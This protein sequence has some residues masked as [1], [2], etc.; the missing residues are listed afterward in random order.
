[1]WVR[2]TLPS[3]SPV[4]KINR[5]VLIFLG[6]A[7][8]L[9]I[10][11]FIVPVLIILAISLTNLSTSTGFEGWSWVG[12]DNYIRIFRH[13]KTPEHFGMTLKYVFWTLGL[14]NVGMGLLI[15]LLTT[16]IHSRLGTSFR[17]LWL[18]PKILPSVVYVLM[19]KYL[20]AAAPHGIINIFLEPFGIEARNWV[21]SEPF[22]FI[23]LI[24]GYIG[25]SFGMIIFTSAIESIPKDY[26]RAAMVDGAGYLQR[27]RHI[28][29]PAIKWPLLFVTTYQ[30]LSLLTSFEQ[31]MIMNDGANGTEVWALWAYHNALNNYYGN[32]QW[33]FGAS[34]SAVL[35]LFGVGFCYVY[36]R[37]FKFKELVKRP[38]IDAL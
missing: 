29:L 19:W 7:T 2:I 33:G 20:G 14:F 30:T 25:A 12:L 18:L 5:D 23:V 37:F 28:I 16:S 31:I 6:P 11:F 17:A 8:F 34:L 22:V 38:Q 26:I 36:M 24:N 13:P 9:V 32:F 4:R 10:L 3:S 1:M 27:V 35:V 21:T 15:A